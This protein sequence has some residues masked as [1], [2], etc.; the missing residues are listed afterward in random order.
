M[1][2]GLAAQAGMP[3]FGELPCVR[4]LCKIALIPNEVSARVPVIPD[5]EVLR[6]IGRGAYGEIWLAR[7]LTGAL[8]A[9]KIVYRSTFESERAFQREF[10]G[11][12]SF[13]PISRAHAGFVD[14]LHVGRTSEYLYYIME[15]AD[16][17]LAG[18]K[19][20]VVNYEPRTL[21]S[22]LDR[23]KRLSASESIQLG[24]SLTEALQ[25]LHAHGLTHRDIKPSNIIFIDGVPK[26]ADIGLVAA[27]GQRSFVGTEGYVPPEGPGTPRADIYSLGK[28]LYETCTGKDRLDFPEVDSQLST[29]PDRE[30]LLQLNN[31]LVKACANDLNKR[32][33]SAAEMHRD[34]AALEQ[35][36]RPRKSRA[37]NLLVTLSL[38][39][40][41]VAAIGFWLR[42]SQSFDV[43]LQTTIRT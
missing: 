29:R 38:V 24:L 30:R 9:V 19:I 17:H 20:D 32:Y 2:S 16:D 14:I 35:G 10:Q 12:S 8:R 5:H 18:S 41:L 4:A 15:L 3:L 23:Q 1:L 21:K 28:L 36:E 33:D 40:L 31:V 11:M 42:P 39:V 27:T 7:S 22:D 43:H 6:V 25:A 13:E 37:K 26:L 34:L